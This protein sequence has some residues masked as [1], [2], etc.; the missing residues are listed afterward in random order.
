MVESLK[1]GNPVYARLEYIKVRGSREGKYSIKR[2]V[3]L[4]VV[5][6]ASL[7]KPANSLKE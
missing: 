6:F 2:S 7:E 3:K 1:G 5:I 4:I